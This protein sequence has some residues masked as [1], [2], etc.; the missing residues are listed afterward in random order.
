MSTIKLSAAFISIST[1]STLIHHAQNSKTN[2]L[3]CKK[4]VMLHY[5]LPNR[6]STSAANSASSIS[7]GR[8]SSTLALAWLLFFDGALASVLVEQSWASKKGLA[9]VSTP[10]DGGG[11]LSDGERRP[12]MQAFSKRFKNEQKEPMYSRA[13][14]GKS[15]R[16]S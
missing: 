14:V 5:P 15:Y 2:M 6:L 9:A 7:D 16:Q 4:G 1:M 12:P 3:H 10:F 8:N 13:K 11:E